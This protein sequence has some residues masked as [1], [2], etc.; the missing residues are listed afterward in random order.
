MGIFFKEIFST[1]SKWNLII[2][3]KTV[4]YSDSVIKELNKTKL[5]WREQE[6]PVKLMEASKKYKQN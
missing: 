4:K 3:D 6:I 5:L 2:E 1:S